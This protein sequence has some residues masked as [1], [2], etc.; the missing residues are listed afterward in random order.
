MS[1]AIIQ[2]IIDKLRGKSAHFYA[3]NKKIKILKYADVDDDTILGDYTYIGEYTSITKSTIGRYC[4]IANNV[5]IGAGEHDISK[6]STNT[7]L[8][9]SENLFQELTK[10]PLTIKNDVWIGTG[11]IIR[12][13]ITIGNCAVIGSN[14]FVNKDVPDFAVVGGSP[15]RIIK[16]RFDEE[17]RA[18]ILA[19]K[20]W[21]YEPKEAKEIID[22]LSNYYENNKKKD[23]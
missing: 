12:R 13:G 4:S 22:K 5:V 2:K 9:D 11:S 15:A 23:E 8:I 19:S 10:N 16:Y 14:S 20:Y 6:I 3:F 7:L 18:K 21:E 1:I 17:T